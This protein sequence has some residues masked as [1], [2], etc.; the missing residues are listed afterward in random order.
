MP[1]KSSKGKKERHVS[2]TFSR[3]PKR[4]LQLRQEMEERKR[5]LYRSEA[6]RRE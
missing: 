1:R 4:S 2:F 6:R 5:T 3:H